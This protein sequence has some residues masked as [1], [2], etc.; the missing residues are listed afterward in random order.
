MQGL[1]DGYF[2]LPYTVTNYLAS[3]TSKSKRRSPEARGAE[4]AA[5]AD[6]HTSV[7]AKGKRTATDFTRNSKICGPCWDGP[8]EGLNIALKRIPE[9]EEFWK[10]VKIPGSA[11]E[12]SKQLELADGG[13]FMELGELM[14]QM[15]TETSCGGISARSSKQ[16]T[17]RLNAT[18][19]LSYVAA[20]GALRRQSRKSLKEPL[21][22]NV[23]PTQRS[24]K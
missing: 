19:P 14:A 7:G 5:Q 13:R 11:S 24:Y 2:V 4:E 12:S 21:F 18:T 9:R 1:N 22:E 20:W 15:P 23:K 3:Q 17:A 10:S 16:R 6:R 8:R